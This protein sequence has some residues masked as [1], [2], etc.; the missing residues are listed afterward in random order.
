MKSHLILGDNSPFRVEK[1]IKTMIR[2]LQANAIKLSKY[3]VIRANDCQYLIPE[4]DETQI[5]E[6]PAS[7]RH[8]SESISPT[9]PFE[10]QECITTKGLD[11]EP[12][13]HQTFPGIEMV[14]IAHPLC[15]GG[16]LVLRHVQGNW[17]MVTQGPSSVVLA[18]CIQRALPHAKA[19]HFA[20][21]VVAEQNVR[22]DSS[23]CCC[24]AVIV[25][26]EP[27]SFQV[28][29][30]YK[31]I[32][33]VSLVADVTWTV[34]TALAFIASNIKCNPE[35]ISLKF[36]D[37]WT[38]EDDFL[39]EYEKF[40]FDIS[41]KACLPGYMS[42]AKPL[43]D[44]EV[45][46][47]RPTNAGRLR[48]VARHPS[49]KMSISVCV[50]LD[51]PVGD[52]MRL[53]FPDLV[54]HIAWKVFDGRGQ[55]CILTPCGSLTH[56]D[57]EWK[58]FKPLVVTRVEKCS[59]SMPI[60]D[61]LCT[62]PDNNKVTRWIK[63]P[64]ASKAK[65]VELP[66]DMLVMQIA[67]SF[68]AH[69]QCKVSVMCQVVPNIIDPNMSVGEID[70]AWILSF[71]ITPL[72]GGAKNDPL[73]DRV[74]HLL[75]TKGVPK[76]LCN[77]RTSSFL[78]K[79]DHETILKVDPKNIDAFWEVIKTEANRVKFRLVLHSE[80]TAHK[81]ENRHEPPSKETRKEKRPRHEGNDFDLSPENIVIDI[82]HFKVG[83]SNVV[84]LDAARFG[85]DQ[86]GIAIMN[87][88]EASKHQAFGSLSPDG[89]AILVI[90]KNL[91]NFKDVFV[92]PAH[93][94]SGKPV[95]IQAAL[96]NF[97]DEKIRY[98][99]AVPS[100]KTEM[101]RATIIEFH[102]VKKLVSSWKD[103]SN[104]LHYIGVHVP[105]LRGN[106]LLASWSHKT[107]TDDRKPTPFQNADYWHGFF[108]IEDTHLEAT[109]ARSGN[110][111]IFLVPKSPDKKHDDRF[112]IIPLP[113]CTLQEV[114]QKAQGCE[115][116]LGITKVRD[117]F[118]IRC[119]C[120]SV[121]KLRAVLFPESACVD[122]DGFEVDEKLWILKNVPPISK[123][124]L[125]RGLLDAKWEA[126]TVR[127]QGHDR[128]I[129]ASKNQPNANHLVINDS[130]VLVEPFM[131]SK[132]QVPVTFT[133][134]EFKVDTV[135]DPVTGNYQVSTTSRIAEVK[136]EMSDQINQIVQQKL[137]EANKRIDQLTDALKAA[138]DQQQETTAEMR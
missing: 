9:I 126:H 72:K 19:H 107:W 83:D 49:K 70:G 133:A 18:D 69:A 119:K 138:Q 3:R 99:A 29:C 109:L 130:L 105:C 137:E 16:I 104:P 127:S 5:D 37:L 55:D 92:M 22:W 14:D 80:L 57:V 40:D 106:N 87:A 66:S 32:L 43:Q 79:A 8:K 124:A 81:K 2:D 84:G 102:I 24:P 82:N 128:W 25:T 113:S 7:K 94:A 48:F 122:T 21:F 132:E 63:T 65:I 88:T 61:P 59:T 51:Q 44:I 135:V 31:S 4:V 86:S 129:V 131:R 112:A 12:E 114:Q 110:A 100:I 64:F 123:E 60:D 117:H 47:L 74:K 41:F 36:G 85:P 11:F 56:F 125:N 111:G 10:V 26:F 20:A 134:K 34:K 27:I 42:F 62:W 71:K 98:I 97:G 90:D 53:C 28:I 116:A 89:L 39:L 115:K 96:I 91:S 76:D 58:C 108:K 136:A 6:P 52:V 95:A 75:E 15:Q 45:D 33:A 73:K 68:V 118:A 78:A 38:K 50:A 35:V 120:E 101:F 77:E 17:M 67:A 121:S 23:I 30:R 54:G 93:T 46:G 13:F 103:C 1:D